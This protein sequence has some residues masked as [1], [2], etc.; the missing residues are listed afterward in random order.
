M[1]RST[2]LKS[3][4]KHLCR[5]IPIIVGVAL[6]GGVPALCGAAAGENAPIHFIVSSAA[7]PEGAEN[8]SVQWLTVSAPSLGKMLLA[9]AK[10]A[11]KGPFPTILL[12]HGS[13]GFAREYVQLA[14]S[15]AREGVLAV[16]ACW[17]DGGTG[18]GVK[19]IKPLGCPNAPPMPAHMSDAS[20][21]ALEV[22][23]P[24]TRNLPDTA[25]GPIALFGHSR[26]AGTALDYALVTGDARAVVLNSGGYPP[27]LADRISQLKAPV[28]ILHGVADGPSEGGSEMTQVQMARNFEAAVRR[29]GKPLE[30]HYY[31][32]N[33]N[34]LFTTP[35]Q[36]ADTV[37]R[38]SA[39]VKRYAQ[40]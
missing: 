11:G 23:V 25:P 40:H 29:A 32:A 33:H 10:P 4:L 8:L 34:G 27:D 31:E 16:A 14:Q 13:H 35:A 20:R 18:S 2:A 21:K 5:Q 30:A 28:L 12:L 1:L 38:I 36:Y 19:F 24:A 22:L 6:L 7:A 9:V 26:G 15:L 37:R 39:F 17:F 3:P